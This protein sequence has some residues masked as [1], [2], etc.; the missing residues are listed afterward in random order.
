[1][2]FAPAAAA[3]L[4]AGCGPVSSHAESLAGL[5]QLRIP[6]SLVLTLED[7]AMHTRDGREP[8]VE[9][10]LA[11]LQGLR[12][13]ARQRGLGP[14]LDELQKNWREAMAT[15]DTACPSQADGRLLGSATAD[16]AE[17]IDRVSSR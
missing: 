15:A 3:V 9:R 4:L 16:L 11:L 7:C 2:R 6:Y 13:T 10:Q 1:M 14:T 17:A 8:A 12:A 5:D